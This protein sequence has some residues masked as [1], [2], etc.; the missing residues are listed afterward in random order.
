MAHTIAASVLYTWLYNGT[1]GS[2]LLV[3]LFH[4]GSNTTGVFMPMANTVSSENMGTY[5]VFVLLE[6]IMAVVIIVVTGPERLSRTE[7]MQ[8]QSSALP[9]QIPQ[10][11]SARA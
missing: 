1:K 10:S 11:V 9:E 8:E 2:L 3:A 6:V 5:I 7:P 4:A